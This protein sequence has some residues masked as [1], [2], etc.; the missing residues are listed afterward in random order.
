MPNLFEHSR[1][2]KE[3]GEANSTYKKAGETD[4]WLNLLHDNGYLNATQEIDTL[5][6]EWSKM[7]KSARLGWLMRE[8]IRIN[9]LINQLARYVQINGGFLNDTERAYARKL[10]EMYQS[11]V[12]E[13]TKTV[14]ELGAEALKEIARFL[15]QG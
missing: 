4:Y 6:A 10:L 5:H 15:L 13:G 11:V 7:D 8:K 14:Q 12:A 1:G 9:G 2:A 3:E